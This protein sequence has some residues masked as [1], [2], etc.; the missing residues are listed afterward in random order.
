MLYRLEKN[1]EPAV[2]KPEWNIKTLTD[3]LV[4][5]GIIPEEIAGD[6][7]LFNLLLFVQMEKQLV[8]NMVM[9]RGVETASF[10]KKYDCR[11]MRLNLLDTD[12]QKFKVCV[13][14]ET[15]VNVDHYHRLELVSRKHKNLTA[16]KSVKMVKKGDLLLKS[17]FLFFSTEL[18]YRV[19]L[20]LFRLLWKTHRNKASFTRIPSSF[21]LKN[22]APASSGLSCFDLQFSPVLTWT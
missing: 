12:I 6:S 20:L 3:L 4:E 19:L 10:T 17:V 16:P 1:G 11:R 8:K 7:S 2:E 14:K 21:I 9:P 22:S 18:F 5:K 15:G 13:E